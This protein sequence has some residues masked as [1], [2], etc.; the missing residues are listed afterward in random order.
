MSSI[1]KINLRALKIASLGVFHKSARGGLAT[2][3]H[4]LTDSGTRAGVDPLTKMAIC[5]YVLF[6]SKPMALPT[7]LHVGASEMG[8]SRVDF[9]NSD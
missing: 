7:F 3:Q 6:Y 2:C 5:M 4:F 1:K 8:V 9:G